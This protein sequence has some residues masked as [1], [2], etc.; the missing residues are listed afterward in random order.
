MYYKN[1]ILNE[2]RLCVYSK[3]KYS[4]KFHTFFTLEIKRM[5]KYV[6]HFH[7]RYEVKIEKNHCDLGLPIVE[8]WLADNF[9][10][11]KN[12]YTDIY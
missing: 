7:T 2:D 6:L 10:N 11:K 12:L 4:V 1:R 3:I 5:K 9:I 8:G